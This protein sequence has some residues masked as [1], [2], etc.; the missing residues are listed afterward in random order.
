LEGIEKATGINI[1]GKI[2]EF[3]ESSVEKKNT[4][5]KTTPDT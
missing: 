2:I 1:A 3:V 4:K 5:R